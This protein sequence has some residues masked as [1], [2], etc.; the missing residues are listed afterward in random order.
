MKYKMWS[1]TAQ[2]VSYVAVLSN[3]LKII[4]A[5][6]ISINLFIYL[7][8]LLSWIQVSYNIIS[9]SVLALVSSNSPVLNFQAKH[10]LH[11]LEIV[12][13]EIK[14]HLL[15]YLFLKLLDVFSVFL[16]K[17]EFSNPLPLRS[18]CFL[19]YSSDCWNLSW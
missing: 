16:R 14:C 1:K 2:I 13:C 19:F 7:F 18:H 4:I 10:D 5:F 9:I 6:R 8:F 15:F 12:L 11:N 3:H 17:N